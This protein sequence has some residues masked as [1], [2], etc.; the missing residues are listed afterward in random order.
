MNCMRSVEKTAKLKLAFG[1]SFLQKCGTV[2][3]FDCLVPYLHCFF[4]IQL[5]KT[6][7]KHVNMAPESQKMRQF[8]TFAKMICQMPSSIWLFSVHSSS[9]S[10]KFDKKWY[11]YKANH[12]EPMSR[13]CW[14]CDLC[15]CPC[16][17]IVFIQYYCNGS[18]RA[19]STSIPLTLVLCGC[20]CSTVGVL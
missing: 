15:G 8:H 20:P 6:K 13:G 2:S 4:E 9:N 18:H 17:S 5:P 19:H 16:H 7:K 11:S 3:F 14:C 10:F 12:R 1:M